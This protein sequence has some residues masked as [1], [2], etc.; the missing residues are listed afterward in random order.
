MVPVRNA[1][2]IFWIA[3]V[4][5][6][7]TVAFGL[8]LSQVPRPRHGA[9]F[10]IDYLCWSFAIVVLLVGLLS[11]RR[12]WGRWFPSDDAG[13]A[14]RA[15]YCATWIALSLSVYALCSFTADR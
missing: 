6:A 8:L 4:V 13:R 12:M 10:R 5:G 1:M 2:W 14:T 3:N 15:A 9:D 11:G 7:L